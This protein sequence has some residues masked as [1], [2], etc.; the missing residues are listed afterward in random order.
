MPACSP[1]PHPSSPPTLPR[2]ADAPQLRK[3][4]GNLPTQKNLLEKR[5]KGAGDKKYF[6]S[7]DW[8]KDKKQP[9]NPPADAGT[10]AAGTIPENPPQER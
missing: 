10:S 3:K 5:Q 8:A 4:Y 6:D 7:A 9:Q 2:A 1:R